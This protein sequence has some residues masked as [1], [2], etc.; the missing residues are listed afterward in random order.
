MP[1]S[2]C[3]K[4]TTHRQ[5]KAWQ[6]WLDEQWH[7]PSR[8]DHY[9]MQIAAE[10][11]LIWNF[12]FG[13]KSVPDFSEFLLKFEK[14]RPLTPMERQEQLDQM[15]TWSQAIWRSRLGQTDE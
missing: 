12:L 3:M 4:R 2:E 14:K 10:V 5:Y 15:V 6:I 1:V 13:D 11:H 7:K 8:A 9:A